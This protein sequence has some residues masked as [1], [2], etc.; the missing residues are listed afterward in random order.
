LLNRF[1]QLL[2]ATPDEIDEWCVLRLE[3]HP[4]YVV[5]I[6]GHW[7]TVAHICRRLKI[8]PSKFRR[9]LK[10]Y[11]RKSARDVIAGPSGRTLQIRSH[12]S[13]DRFLKAIA[14]NQ[15]SQPVVLRVLKNRLAARRRLARP[16][17]TSGARR[18]AA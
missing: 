10:R 18:K 2:G 13:L 4:L 3:P 16:T 17:I 1:L 7:E 15:S 5:E 6:R 8:S 11:P 9:R 14:S 12:L